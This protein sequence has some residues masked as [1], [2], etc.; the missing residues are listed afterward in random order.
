MADAIQGALAGQEYQLNKFAIQEAPVKLE[1]EKL[2]LQ[3]GKL[4]FDKQQKMAQML[5]GMQI[6][7]GQD[8]LENAKNAFF[9]M[10]TAAA[11]TGFPEEAS[12]FLA[13]GAQIAEHQED[14]AYK[15]WETT[16]QQTK[17]A[18][19]IL[20]SVTDQASLD[21]ANAYIKMTQGKDSL[22]NGMKWNDPKTQST[23]KMLKESSIKKRTDA[24]ENLDKAKAARERSLL[25]VDQASIEQKKSAAE[26]NKAR[27]VLADKHGN[28]GIVADPKN[29]SATARA[30]VKASNDTMSYNDAMAQADSMALDVEQRMRD[31]NG[32]TRPQ[33]ILKTIQQYQQNGLLNF[34]DPAHIPKGRSPR[35]AVDL[36]KDGKYRD[37]TWYKNPQGDIR[38]WDETTR[39]FYAKGEGPDT[40]GPVADDEAEE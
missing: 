3:I 18:D 17:L 13:K 32:M 27:K 6:P 21:S 9:G 11:K 23:I 15:R 16:L 36:P 12:S 1:R 22:L 29:I 31:T 14:A 38:W 34:A 35:T 33:A 7:T 4:D 19:D 39:K 25:A 5:S 30:L 24:Q 10:A 8:P 40:P 20:G 2:A 26:L 28:A 37:Q